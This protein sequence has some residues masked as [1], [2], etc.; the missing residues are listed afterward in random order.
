MNDNEI[1]IERA[2]E[3]FRRTVAT[4]T[5]P[6]VWL[7]AETAGDSAERSEAATARPAAG[8]PLQPM[9]R[10]APM[11]EPAASSLADERLVFRVRR[12]LLIRRA[13]MLATAALL[14]G[15]LLFSPWGRGVMAEM[16]HTFRVQKL[17][18]VDLNDSDLIRLRDALSQGI[19]GTARFDLSRY[20]ELEQQGS[21]KERNVT[22]DDAVELSDGH[23][24]TWP[25]AGT[26]RSAIVYEPEQQLVFRLHA[27]EI[28]RLAVILGG[29]EL[30][31]A[32]ADGK[33]VTL[34]I[35]GTF[36]TEAA[37]SSDGSVRK[38][39]FQ[40]PVPSLDVP[41]DLDVEQIRQALLA[42]PQLPDDLRTKLAAISDWQH[43]LPIPSGGGSIK[44]LQL[45]G[46][47]AVLS[48]LESGRAIV[49]LQDGWLYRLIG[50]SS[51]YPDDE[52][53]IS[54]AKGLIGS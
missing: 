4:E 12:R 30:I 35:P 10:T 50:S 27:K 36:R 19:D 16:L 25:A 15:L 24:K 48:R 13:G 6:A 14:S 5:V 52:S 38:V 39:L 2:W 42:L 23:F 9:E 33:P 21:G 26:D 34:R 18:V 3:R 54:D 17:E 53:I 44:A 11:P 49:W 31:P 37:V 45:N 28:N 47:D 46:L 1:D 7:A 22:R 40:L 51:V 29:K 32:S 20:G 43:T 8:L 41:K